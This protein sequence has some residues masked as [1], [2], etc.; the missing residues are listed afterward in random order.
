MKLATKNCTY[1][2]KSLIYS[3]KRAKLKYNTR[4]VSSKW[5]LGGLGHSD[6]DAFVILSIFDFLICEMASQCSYWD[7]SLS[8]REVT[9]CLRADYCLKVHS[10][11]CEHS[12]ITNDTVCQSGPQ[13][14]L[15]SGRPICSLLR[16]PGLTVW[17]PVT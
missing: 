12:H 2:L 16:W 7:N 9:Q 8:Y 14:R 3:W 5:C 15:F 4:S 1:S 11:K 6:V 13:L 10:L 17:G